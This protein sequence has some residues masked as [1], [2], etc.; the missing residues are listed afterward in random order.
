MERVREASRAASMSRRLIVNADD[1]G[2][3]R[4]VNTGIV[5]ACERGILGATT[6]MANGGAFEHAV[7]LARQTPN[8]DVGC[9]VTLVGGASALD[10]SQ[11]LPA[12]VAGLLRRIAGGW[13]VDSIEA[14][15]RAQ[16][17]KLR[18]AGVEP[19]HLDAHKHTHLIPRVLEALLRVAREYRIPWIRRPFDLP[20]T[21]A[22]AN[23]PWKRRITSRMLRG[24]HRR[25]ERQ[26]AAAGCRGTDYFAGFQITGL[27]R[28]QELAALIRA[29]PPGLTEL[30]THPGHCTAELQAASTRLKQSRAAELEALLAPEVRLAAEEAGV[31][32]TRFSRISPGR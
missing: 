2:F 22:T 21:A 12:S 16:V 17:E 28:T 32:I 20:L 25:F 10:P 26:V 3:T 1:F 31:E 4:D 14:E 6:L 15:V 23:A 19:T 30:M 5:E 11:P 18:A 7:E 8:L 27:Y 29:L 9:H 24:L 13:D